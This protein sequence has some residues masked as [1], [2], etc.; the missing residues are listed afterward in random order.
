V[1]RSETWTVLDLLRWTTGHFAKQGIETA[2]LDAECLLAFAL[3]TERLRLYLDF[4]KPVEESERARFRDLVKR[5][6]AERVPVSHLVGRKEF[7]S[8]ALRVT[9]DV[10]TPRPDTETLVQAAL[11]LLPGREAGANVLD[12]GTGSGAVALALASERPALRVVATDLSADALAIAAENAAA[13]GLSGRIELV[14]G[15]LYDPVA[16]RRF[17]LIVSNPPY[18]AEGEEASLAPE[19]AFEPRMALFAGSEGTECLRALVADATDHLVV[20]GALAVEIAPGQA[21]VVAGWVREAGFGDVRVH[22]DLGRRP[23]VVS[24]RLARSGGNA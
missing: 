18:L 7:W 5:R 22:D 13:L 10:L 11:D 20:G 17:D 14:Q 19:L 1:S 21:P 15:S 24:G 3:G 16:G 9:P 2:R 4:D 12:V 8:L 23:R 6:G